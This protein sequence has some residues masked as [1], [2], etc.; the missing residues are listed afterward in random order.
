MKPPM[1]ERTPLFQA[2]PNGSVY[3]I[4]SLLYIKEETMFLA[5]AE[6]R[7][8][9]N[10]ASAEF[11]AMKRG[12]YKTGYV[13]WE[14][15]QILHEAAM[16][17]HRTMNPCPVYEGKSKTLFLFFNCIPEGV[18]EQH[19]RK[20]GNAS[21]LC[22]VTSKDYGKTWDP[23][24]DITDVTSGIRNLATIF[25]APG[26][27][28]QTES[29]K[30][31]IPAYVY[32]AKF[33]LI[34]W[35]RTSP[36]SFCVYSEDQ[37][38]RWRVSERIGQCETGECELAEITSEDGKKMLYCNARSKGKK[39]I[40]AL[41]LNTDGEFKFVEKSRKLIETNDG[42]SGSVV[43]FPGEEVPGQERSHW[44]LFSHPSKKER[45]GLGIYLNKTPMVSGSWSKPWVI[46]E[47]PSAYSDL[48]DCQDANTFAILFESGEKTPYEEINFCLFT[49]EDVL[50]HIKKKK[51]LFAR[52]MK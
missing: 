16:K 14:G 42:C 33:W 45:R 46:Y 19:M 32:V 12:V 50:E 41:I 18:T 30:L 36:H 23:L 4:P 20:W 11:L 6:K 27:G 51:G 21:K 49:L 2:E 1:P 8:D 3:R 52:L 37:G 17:Q 35:W 5:F 28:I 39:R 24:T 29:G 38:N 26:H 25:L 48:A 10:D 34:H 22:Y 44:V 7:K 43:S 9:A 31:I 40:E 15:V 13:K 47:G